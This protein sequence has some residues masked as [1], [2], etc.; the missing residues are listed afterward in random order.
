MK[1]IK[2]HSIAVLLSFFLG[3]F[4]ADRFYLGH[5]LLGFLKF[6]FLILI[7]SLGSKFSLMSVFFGM[8]IL[9]D[10]ILILLKKVKNVS[11]KKEKNTGLSIFITGIIFFSIIILLLSFMIWFNMESEKLEQ[12]KK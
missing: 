1:Q 2:N 10:F 6:G 9:T 8:V 11:F 7:I 3:G 4:G 5:N 12:K